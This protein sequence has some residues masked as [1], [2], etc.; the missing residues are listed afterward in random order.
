MPEEIKRIIAY[1]PTEVQVT[2][3]EKAALMPGGAELVC[4][5]T[6]MGSIGVLYPVP[7]R[8]EVPSG[9][10]NRFDFTLVACISC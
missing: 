7:N 5:A 6:I 4:Y 1:F 9:L 8:E 3:V 2:A 10:G